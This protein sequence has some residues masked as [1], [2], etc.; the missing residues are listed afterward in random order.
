M[1]PLSTDLM[2]LSLSPQDRRR[3]RS[4]PQK[5]PKLRVASS[6]RSTPPEDF[7]KLGEHSIKKIKRRGASSQIF[8]KAL[9]EQNDYLSLKVEIDTLKKENQALKKSVYDNENLALKISRER[10]LLI[11]EVKALR[12]RIDFME[13]NF[14]RE[15]NNN[16]FDVMQAFDVQIAYLKREL[17]KANRYRNLYETK[18]Q[19]QISFLEEHNQL[20]KENSYGS[21]QS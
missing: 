21:Q 11:T 7:S 12:S 4:R 13:N 18:H 6:L 20:K 14:S 2:R 3:S 16:Y 19:P 9:G 17:G 10:H 15:S 8:E 1:D 5:L